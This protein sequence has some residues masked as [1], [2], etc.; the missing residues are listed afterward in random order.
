M[1]DG[2]VRRLGSLGRI[3]GMVKFLHPYTGYRED[4][5]WDDA[6]LRAVRVVLEAQAD[7]DAQRALDGLLGALGD[8]LTRRVP[9]AEDQVAP[10]RC[11]PGSARPEPALDWLDEHTALV[12]ARDAGQ[13]VGFARDAE[14]VQAC[15]AAATA[16]TVMFDLRV[17]A[18]PLDA[19]GNYLHA[20][21]TS[22]LPWLLQRPVQPLGVR[23]RRHEG[24]AAQTGGSAIYASGFSVRCG[25]PLA[26]DSML[27]RQP[28]LVMLVGPSTIGL[29]DILGGLS[30]SGL[31]V[32]VAE[33]GWRA[34]GTTNPVHW[35]GDGSTAV[36][37]A[38]GEWVWPDGTVG[39]V[40]TV[41]LPAS[42]G[43]P[44]AASDWAIGAALAA[45]DAV[46]AGAAVP[47]PARR[48]GSA[49]IGMRECAYDGV[50]MTA[51]HRLLGL[52]RLWN[53][54]HY[55]F[56]YHDLTP[57]PWDAA[58]ERFVRQ[59]ASAGDQ[60]A[61]LTAVE[62]MIAGLGDSHASAWLPHS[63]RFATPD[64]GVR[65]VGD[66][67][68][69]TFVGD[70]AALSQGV[71]PGDP[72]LAIDGVPIATRRAGLLPTVSGSTPQAL[73]RAVDALLLGGVAGSLA[74]LSI[75]T[76]TGVRKC[77]LE[78]KLPAATGPEPMLASVA[79][80]PPG[81]GY[82][83]LSRVAAAEIASALDAVRHTPALIFDLRRYP[84]GN[85]WALGP[86]LAQNNTVAWATFRCPILSGWDVGPVEDGGI[87][88]RM[89][90]QWAVSHVSVKPAGPW[91][92]AGRIV[93]LIGRDTMS[94]GEY[95]GM[96]LA[97]IGATFVGEPTSGVNGDVTTTL[98]PGR[99]GV[100]FT[101]QAVTWP[102]GSPLQRRGIRP[103]LHVAPSP[104]GLRAGRDEVV[105]A[106][107]AWLSTSGL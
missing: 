107:V 11:A 90:R 47:G 57:S 84:L 62:Q 70:D 12:T 7:T 76:A 92:Y 21:L 23:V 63:P 96:L 28:R 29:D 20:G 26:C 13:F 19:A 87:G 100:A 98:L 16:E 42:D 53:V 82:I 3:W 60:Q 5:D 86:R 50:P 97:A 18:S 51:A 103:A 49:W 64:L 10:A 40:P 25:P 41:P 83:D 80:L 15:R 24:Y 104:E 61:Y 105:D 6:L 94:L 67:T 56:P 95:T 17:R 99:I 102:D 52:F 32:V 8:P 35:R 31:A 38:V 46:W 33:A 93:G 34:T 45:A 48:S 30:A 14:F 39:A 81:I 74:D 43:G 1:E 69:V 73:D 71:A 44:T 22:G 66:R 54:I 27:A 68:V 75:R 79:V 85:A 58:L 101:G 59:F 89:E 4:L 106:A 65:A 78:R 91:Q 88:Y 55:F 2:V 9:V 72:L 37:I 77:S 36:A